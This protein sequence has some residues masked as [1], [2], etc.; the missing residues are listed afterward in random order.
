MNPT[1]W[2]ADD[3][4]DMHRHI[5]GCQCDVPLIDAINVVDSSLCAI[6][7]FVRFFCLAAKL[8]Y[9]SDRATKVLTP[10]SEQIAMASR[11][12]TTIKFKLLGNN[13]AKE[14]RITIVHQRSE[15][16]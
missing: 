13:S 4:L 11:T 2:P 6:V 1:L 15:P 8:G 5:A 12:R 9:T 14:L 7:G 10:T 3:A 16:N